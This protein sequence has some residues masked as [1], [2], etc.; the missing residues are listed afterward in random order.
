MYLRQ[1]FGRGLLIFGKMY[2][3]KWFQFLGLVRFFSSVVFVPIWEHG[4]SF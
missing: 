1:D 2:P 3:K 4:T